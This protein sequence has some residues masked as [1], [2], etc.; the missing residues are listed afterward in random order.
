MP[1]CGVLLGSPCD[2]MVAIRICAVAMGTCMHGVWG[3][4]RI[5]G[6]RHL[7]AAAASKPLVCMQEVVLDPVGCVPRWVHWWLRGKAC[8]WCCRCRRCLCM[9]G[10]VKAAASS[11][12]SCHRALQGFSSA[13]WVGM[14]SCGMYS[15]ERDSVGW[16]VMHC[17]AVSA[18]PYP[19]RCVC[20]VWKAG[21]NLLHVF[22]EC[23]L[24]DCIL[25]CWS[26]GP[27]AVSVSTGSLCA[28]STTQCG[29]LAWA[30]SCMG[31]YSRRAD[32]V[33]LLPEV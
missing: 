27:Q 8:R 9:P 18:S 32:L 1:A 16:Q 30:H 10:S 29:V 14:Q 24:Y 4:I 33:E 6:H 2:S 17:L 25:L 11:L 23:S 5:P 7:A 19:R 13:A 28:A 22:C 20:M 31:G 3:L 26:K 21:T 12:Q 15:Q